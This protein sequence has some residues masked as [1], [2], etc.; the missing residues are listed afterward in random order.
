MTEEQPPFHSTHD[1]LVYAYSFASMSYARPVMVGD[2]PKPE[3]R[4]LGGLD[5][6]GMAGTI[7]NHVLSVTD[8]MEQVALFLR[9]APVFEPGKE[10]VKTVSREWEKKFYWMLWAVRKHVLKQ[11]DTKY[12]G[13]MLMRLYVK[14]DISN[15]EIAERFGLHEST[16]SRHAAQVKGYVRSTRFR[17]GME[18]K[19]FEK[20]DAALVA[21]GVVG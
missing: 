9:Y 16:V 1:A 19:A 8:R 7:L 14:N 2:M 18:Q 6:A 10:A 11:Q 17:K 5:G 15:R 21:A 12:I 3:G 4:G 13:E 20:V